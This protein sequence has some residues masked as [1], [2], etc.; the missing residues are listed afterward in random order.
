[1]QAGDS[2]DLEIIDQYMSDETRP[3]S[4]LSGGETFIVS[5]ALAL[6]LAS[7]SSRRL[8]IESL[9]IDEGFGN[10]DNESLDMVVRALGNLNAQGRKVGIISHTEQI[11]D[12]IFP[13][14]QVVR[15]KASDSTST[16]R[17]AYN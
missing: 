7:L 14:V 12:N 6:G 2:L 10:L 3:V 16:I 15:S 5:L 11:R 13:Q 9:F 8:S 17:I 4:G 1:M